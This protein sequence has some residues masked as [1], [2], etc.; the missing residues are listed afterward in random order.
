MGKV[1]RFKNE[2]EVKER[3]PEIRKAISAML[4]ADK[5]G[6]QV[7]SQPISK[8]DYPTELSEA[9][10]SD[11]GFKKAFE[12][13]TPGRQRAWLLHFNRAKQSET[14]SRRIEKAYEEILS[15]KGFN[16]DYQKKR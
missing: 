15:G 7:P 13:L 16:E 4:K 2:S 8:E 9:F 6:L 12:S 3:E 10:Y 5:K 1:I 11:L 14:R